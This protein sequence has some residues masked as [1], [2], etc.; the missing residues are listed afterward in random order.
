MQPCKYIQ[1]TKCKE[2]T[3]VYYNSCKKFVIAHTAFF[4]K[5]DHPF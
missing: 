1:Y 5:G 3:A 2:C 4:D